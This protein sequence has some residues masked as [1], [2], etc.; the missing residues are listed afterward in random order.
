MCLH[1]HSSSSEAVRQ[2]KVDL[3]SGLALKLPESWSC[4]HLTLDRTTGEHMRTRLWGDE[5][6]V[7]AA[8]KRFSFRAEA[9]ALCIK[10]NKTGY[11]VSSFPRICGEGIHIQKQ[12]TAAAAA[13][14]A[15][16]VAAVAVAGLPPVMPSSG[17]HHRASAIPTP[18]CGGAGRPRL[19]GN[20]WGPRKDSPSSTARSSPASPRG[21]STRCSAAAM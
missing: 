19:C 12:P 8:S 17:R 16:A 15:A 5:E 21:R 4:S 20:A 14:L 1:T 18:R 11:G 9:L 7:S 3:S 13:S 6:A 2:Y 10:K